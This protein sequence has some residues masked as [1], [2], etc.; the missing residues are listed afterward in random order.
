M[1]F[2]GWLFSLEELMSCG[3]VLLVVL[4]I[5]FIVCWLGGSLDFMD[6]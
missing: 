2:F 3:I 5:F 1:F 6:F 4:F